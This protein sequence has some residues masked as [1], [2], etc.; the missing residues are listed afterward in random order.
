MSYNCLQGRAKEEGKRLCQWTAIDECTRLRFIYAL[1]EHTPENSIRFME[2]LRDA[3]SFPIQQIQSDNGTEFAYRFNGET[4][5]CPF[6][7]YLCQL[8]TIHKSIAPYNARS[9]VAIAMTSDIFT[10]LRHS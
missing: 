9:S 7:I 6:E 5:K 1:E 10:I 4:K 2:M 3:F 8:K